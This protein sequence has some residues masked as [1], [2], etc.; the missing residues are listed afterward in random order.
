[1]TLFEEYSNPS[2][3]HSALDSNKALFIDTHLT[4]TL[5]HLHF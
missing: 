5:L 4:L 2:E 1:M 3:E